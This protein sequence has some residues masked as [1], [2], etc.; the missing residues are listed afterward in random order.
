MQFASTKIKTPQHSSKHLDSKFTPPPGR[1]WYKNIP[2]KIRLNLE[3]MR[4]VVIF[5]QI[6]TT[7]TPGFS[8][9][10]HHLKTCYD[11]SLLYLAEQF[12]MTSCQ[13]TRFNNL[14]KFLE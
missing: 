1:I 9:L 7:N 11:Y 12:S 10:A 6:F 2:G 4:R 14:S 8:H 3:S 5:S 13:G